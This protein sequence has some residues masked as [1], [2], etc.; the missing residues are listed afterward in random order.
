MM[1]ARSAKRKMGVIVRGKQ[2]LAMPKEG[3]SNCQ[4]P[5]REH[6]SQPLRSG[7]I[8]HDVDSLLTVEQRGR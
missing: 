3:A 4:A 8:L 2:Q 6:D 1:F 5:R 7:S